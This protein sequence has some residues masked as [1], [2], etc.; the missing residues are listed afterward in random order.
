MEN[1]LLPYYKSEGARFLKSQSISLSSKVFK[2]AYIFFLISFLLSLMVLGRVIYTLHLKFAFL[3]WNLFLAWIPFLLSIWM[4]YILAKKGDKSFKSVLLYV[5]GV[6]WLLFF[7][8]A[9]YIFTDFIHL[10]LNDY[11]VY[12][13]YRFVFSNE[14]IIWYDF[15]L[16]SLFSL[17]GIIL[18]FFSLYFIQRNFLQKYMKGISWIFVLMVSFLSGFGIYLGR[19]IRLN[20][21]EVITN[22]LN[23]FIE[24]ANILN[25]DTMLLSTLFG[26]F[27]FISYTIFYQL[28]VFRDG[29][30]I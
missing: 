19:F 28:T 5:L 15:V 3:I 23:L 10:T 27:I 30:L 25:A 6:F 17:L 18:G 14:F 20:S 7:P 16:V 26:T 1:N 12:E 13:N 8:N 9:P 21:W 24:I 22:P 4:V 29:E 2:I 11:F